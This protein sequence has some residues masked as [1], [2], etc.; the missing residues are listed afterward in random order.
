MDETLLEIL[1]RL[2]PGG[3]GGVNRIDDIINDNFIPFEDKLH[4][5]VQRN[6]IIDF[7][8]FI[9]D[10]VYFYKEIDGQ[11]TTFNNY[12]GITK[13]VNEEMRVTLT[14]TGLKHLE[15]HRLLVS[16]IRLNDS[17]LLSNDIISA[18]TTTQSM[19]FKFQTWVFVFGALFAFGSL[20]IAWKTY[21]RD[22]KI[23][24]LEFQLSHLKKDSLLLQ[25][26]LLGIKAN[27]EKSKIIYDTIY[28]KKP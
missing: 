5:D 26:K 12:K 19:I 6:R 11:I 24:Q 16:T 18:N 10:D 1:E 13:W 3:I 28:P 27:Q 8:T 2:E 22:N 20:G 25:N 14:N 17:T 4:F 9:K 21:I 15:Q 23:Q 7:L